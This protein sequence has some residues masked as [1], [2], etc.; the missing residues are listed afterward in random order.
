MFVYWTAGVHDRDVDS[1][2]T[3][4]TTKKIDFSFAEC[5]FP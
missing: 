4:T 2:L 3:Y 1:L 5:N